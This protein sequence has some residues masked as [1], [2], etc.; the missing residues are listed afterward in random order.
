M[1]IK[2]IDLFCGI[3]GLTYGI[4][5]AGFNVIAGIDFDSTCKNTYEKNTHSEFIESD[6]RKI[7]SEF[8]EKKWDGADVK[9]LMGCAPCQPFSNHQKDKKNRKNHK[10]WN[11]LYEFSRLIN[12]TFPDVVSM[13]NVP[14]L[15]HEEV[16]NEF[17]DNLKNNNYYVTYRIINAADYGV[18]QRRR[19]LLLLASKI[20]DIDFI[21]PTHVNQVVTVEDV[22]KKLPTISAGEQAE[23]D[24]LHR[25]A[26]LKDINLK[27][28]RFSTPGGTWKDWPED[29]ILECHKKESGSSYKAVYGRMEWNKV[30]PT[31]TTQFYSYGTGRFGHPD[32]DR[33]I[34]LRE[35][36]LL[37]SF[38]STYNFIFDDTSFVS[39]ARHIGNAV[40]PRLGEVIGESI[41][42]HLKLLGE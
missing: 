7:S 4:E 30:A 18:P 41:K 17:V 1:Q 2:V 13:E 16:F 31:I 5:K 20:G 24:P 3:G 9:I 12:E 10:D 38:P 28:I 22:I 6:I 36:A 26:N 11:L 8:I 32:Q 23:S 33:A 39:I 19:R 42:E 14:S 27:R 35:G 37:Q 40:P 25:A 21:S 34:T 15:Q 29:L